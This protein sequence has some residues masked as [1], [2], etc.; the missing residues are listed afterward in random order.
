MAR[1]P[2][3]C[4]QGMDNAARTKKTGNRQAVFRPS[5]YYCDYCR[6]LTRRAGNLFFLCIAT[7]VG[8]RVTDENIRWRG[9]LT[10]VLM[11]ALR[12]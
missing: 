12:R 11:V 5:L 7:V 9:L 3:L 6:R 4:L 10:V 8:R 2:R 1:A